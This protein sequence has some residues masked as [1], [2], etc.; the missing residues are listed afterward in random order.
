MTVASSVTNTVSGTYTAQP[1]AVQVTLSPV[2]AVNAGAQWQVDGGAFHTSGTVVS[3]LT[4]GSHTVAFKTATGWNPPASQSVTLA[5]GVT[6]TVAGAYTAQPAQLR[7]TLSPDGAISAGA[8]WQVDGGA[9][10]ASGAVVSNLPAGSHTVAYKTVSGWN[11]PGSQT[12]PLTGGVINNLSGIFSAPDT[13]KPTFSIISPTSGLQTTNANF[14]LTGKAADNVALAGVYYQLNGSSWTAAGSVNNWT[15]WTAGVT[16]TPGTN[17]I[18]AYAKDTSGNVANTNSVTFFYTVNTP[19]TVHT[20]GRGSLSPNYNGQML[21]IGKGY[22]MSA[23]AVSGYG[24][25]GWT[26]SLTSSNTTISF[27]MSPNLSLTASFVDVQKPTLS[28]TSPS[29]GL[30]TTNASCAIA[31]KAADNVAVAGVYYQLNGSLWTAGPQR[32][33]LE[34]IGRR[35]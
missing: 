20:N 28:I 30:Q 25:A 15:N 29:S 34:P 6:N 8:Q 26:G 31:G 23:A 10:Q 27:I 14:T 13:T 7:V 2:G 24:F 33:Q 18:R 19:L 1:A 22:T 21:A 17:T 35:A 4:A 32:Q 11:A 9:F 3:G 12:V 16:L 5:N